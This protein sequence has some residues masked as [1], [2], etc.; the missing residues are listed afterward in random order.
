MPIFFI[1]I[2]QEGTLE[3]SQNGIDW[4]SSTK[5]ELGITLGTLKQ[6]KD[7]TIIYSRENPLANS[8]GYAKEIFQIIMSAGLPI[9]LVNRKGSDGSWELE[10]N[11]ESGYAN[12][13]LFTI[14]KSPGVVAILKSGSGVPDIEEFSKNPDELPWIY[15]LPFK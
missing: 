12:C 1:N 7:N 14:A 9:K 4:L 10:P 6:N 15:G 13:L 2:H 5:E 3:V 11:N 8:A